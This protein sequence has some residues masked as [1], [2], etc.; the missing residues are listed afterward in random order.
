MVKKVIHLEALEEKINYTFKN[1]KLLITALTHVSHPDAHLLGNYQRLEFLGDRVLGLV[2]S[3]MLYSSFPD[4]PEG[5]L[6]RRLAELVRKETCADVAEK[7]EVSPFIYL[8]T[9]EHQSGGRKNRTILADICEAILG[10]IFLDGGLEAARQLIENSFRSMLEMPQRPLRDAKTALQEWVQ[11]QGY[12]PPV[13]ELVDRKGPDHSPVFYIHAVTNV[14]ESG[15]GKGPSKREAEQKAAE[16]VLLRE[17][18]WKK[19]H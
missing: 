15:L 3:Q 10:A 13:Y 19:D 1:K 11:S 9:S 17:G 8:G 2:V 4:A 6:S 14:V 5:E 7:W 18:I 12:P 16:T